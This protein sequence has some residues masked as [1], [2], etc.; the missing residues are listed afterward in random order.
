MGDNRI[1]LDS[2]V[3]NVVVDVDIDL[4][5]AG[6]RCGDDW[7]GHDQHAMFGPGRHAVDIEV[8]CKL[9]RSVERTVASAGMNVFMAFGDLKLSSS[10]NSQG[11][12]IDGH[13]DRFWI[14]AR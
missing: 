12:P 9:E 11:S 2:V 6:L 13:V 3:D 1:S 10:R 7:N 4:N 5:L 14:H 8:V